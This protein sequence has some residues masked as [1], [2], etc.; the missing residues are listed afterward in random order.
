MTEELDKRTESSAVNVPQFVWFVPALALLFAV[1]PLPYAYYTGLRWLISASVAFLVW[2]KFEVTGSPQG[3]FIWIF[4]GITLLFN[5]I[6][7][8]VLTKSTWVLIDLVVAGIFLVHWRL[9]QTH[10]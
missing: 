5:P 7:P 1:L 4:G 9:N 3:A 8:V 6:I 2:K 10:T